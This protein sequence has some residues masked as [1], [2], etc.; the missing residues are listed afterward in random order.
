MTDEVGTRMP[1]RVT[2]MTM[3][4]DAGE[5]LPV[6]P[7]KVQACMAMADRCGD[8]GDSDEDDG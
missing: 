1:Q 8:D 4:F 5:F 7:L 2:M 6:L 3:K